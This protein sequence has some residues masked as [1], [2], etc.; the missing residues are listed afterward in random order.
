[1][2]AL[3]EK[4]NMALKS[5]YMLMN[6]EEDLNKIKA[7]EIGGRQ[8]NSARPDSARVIERQKKGQ[9]EEEG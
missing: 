9:K 3:L 8:G 6:Q 7:S 4:K 1:M 5:K 2:D